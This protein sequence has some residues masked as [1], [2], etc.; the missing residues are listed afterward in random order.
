V[1][2]RE[3]PTESF[4]LTLR[5]HFISPTELDMQGYNATV[6]ATIMGGGV[7]TY[8][9]TNFAEEGE[10]AKH[11]DRRVEFTARAGDEAITT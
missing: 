5:M 11:T 9:D 6:C 8:G 4:C 10:D 2:K 1:S 7:L 3:K